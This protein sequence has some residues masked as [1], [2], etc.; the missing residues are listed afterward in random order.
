[1]DAAESRAA[2]APE[3]PA[4]EAD[5]RRALRQRLE[6]AIENAIGVLDA[7]DAEAEDLEP[8]GDEEP[9]PEDSGTDYRPPYSGPPIEERYRPFPWPRERKRLSGWKTV[10]ARKGGSGIRRRHTSG[11]NRE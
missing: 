1:M 11:A 3:V 10:E 6:D 4:L 7:L 2:I 8:T 5:E 9:G